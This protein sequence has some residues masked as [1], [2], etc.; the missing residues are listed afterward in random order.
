M[1]NSKVILKE[2]GIILQKK[3][4][5]KRNT[6]KKAVKSSK[7]SG[8][9]ISGSSITKKSYSD[10]IHINII[11]ATSIDT[12][13]LSRLKSPIQAEN[14]SHGSARRR[15]HAV[16][17][18]TFKSAPPIPTA[19]KD[20]RAR[21]LHWIKNLIKTHL[22]QIDIPLIIIT[23]V[24]TFFGLLSIS[25]ATRSYESARFVIIQFL[26]VG[27]GFLC[28]LA[29][30]VIDYKRLASKYT[31]FIALN[32]AMLLIT[33]IFGSS[34]TEGTN[35][36]W[37]DL[38]FIK[39]QPSEFSKLLFIFTFAVHL[40]AVRDRM[41]RFSTVLTLGLHAAIIFSLVLLQKDLG[42]LTIFLII[43]ICMCFAAGLS[44]WYYIAGGAA[45]IC[46]FPFLWAHLNEYQRNR[47]LLCFDK[48]IDPNGTGIRFQ[49]LQSQRAIGNGGIFGT[50]FTQ[51]SI[52]QGSG[53]LPAKHTDMIFS[54]ICE[55]WGFIGALVIL[56]LTSILILR[57]FKIALSCG[58]TTGRYICVGVASMLMIQVIENVGMCLGIMPVIGITFPFLS[59]GGSSILS[60]FL[61][62]GMV[63][64]VST[65]MDNSMF[66]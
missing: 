27:L 42:S 1:Y 35:S 60:C 54:T 51:G 17:N 24:I 29:L 40:S 6:I 30:S 63:L 7:A 13:N 36:N 66:K 8:E 18:L 46:V 2:R 58:S 56:G 22:R 62:V 39:I 48:T 53:N 43:F 19:P 50:G 32:A 23:T 16:K 57:V 3:Y 9:D 52:T 31:Y 21:K 47:I 65:H 45:L 28:A 34:V 33:F 59:Y 64:S 38:G 26:G 15:R 61:A 20:P 14:S 37:I 49:Q 44:V 12:T 5:I 11:T 4:S 25:S 41:H 10:D 55:E